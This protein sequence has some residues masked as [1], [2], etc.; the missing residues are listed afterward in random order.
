MMKHGTIFIEN[1]SR[2]L[3]ILLLKSWVIGGLR[4]LFATKI[5]E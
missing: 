2:Y 5:M 3:R 4:E 1:I